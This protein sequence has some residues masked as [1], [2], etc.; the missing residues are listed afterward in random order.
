M[1]N[2]RRFLLILGVL[3]LVVLVFAGWSAW[4]AASEAR[5]ALAAL[6]RL[7]LAAENP[8]MDA[9]DAVAGDLTALESHLVAARSAARPFLL[10]APALGWL[11]RVGPYAE[12]G[13]AL[14]DVAVEVA[15]GGRQALT[16]LQPALAGLGQKGSADGLGQVVTALRAAEPDLAAADAR[17]A[18]AEELR[19]SMKGAVPGRFRGQLDRLDRILPLARAG[20]QGARVAPA[21]LGADGPRTYLILA[22]NSD[23]MR[24]TG[25]FISAAGFVR[26]ENGRIADMKLTDSYA[27]DNLDEPHPLP[28]APL[29]EQMGAQILLLRD[30]NWSPDFPASAEVARALYAQ[31]QGVL[32]DGAIA[33]DLE[34]ARLLVEALGP[35]SVAGF[36]GPVTGDNVLTSMRRAWETP[37]TSNETLEAAWTSEWWLS[38]K[39]FMGDL[40]SASL[41]RL[42]GGA[43]LNATALAKALLAML[44]GRHL[45]IAVDDPGLSALL[46]AQGWDGALRHAAGQDFLAVVDSNVGFNKVNA[47]VQVEMDYRADNVGGRLQGALTLTYTHGAAPLPADEV[48]DRTPHYG[49]SYDEMIRRCYWDY[50]RVYVPAGATLTASEGLDRVIVELGERDT[51]V[52]AG[53]FM[54]RPGD[55]QIVRLT[56]WLPDGVS[57]LP[58]ALTVRK[59]AGTPPWPVRVN[60]GRCQWEEWL[61]TDL[62]FACPAG[63]D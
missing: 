31:D 29:G 12:S 19:A 1:S 41:A 36:E 11:P 17:L 40:V 9:L 53:V 52:V 14:L 30:S 18:R 61:V 59:Q 20:L 13:P 54:L 25:G 56:Y 33:L 58:Y 4:R 7:Q 48:C 34:A 32:T 62:H 63:V 38:R 49:N 23:E 3:L 24:A 51:T 10:L 42:Q 43:D 50:L 57:L 60:T 37:A 2:G 5:Q 47:A 39:D 26:L 22:Q 35:L 46:A 16:A 45:Q 21:L 8:E 44:D 6:D 15:A 55:T 27:V 28:P